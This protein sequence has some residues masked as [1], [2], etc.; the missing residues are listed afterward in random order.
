LRIPREGGTGEGL[1]AITSASKFFFLFIEETG[2]LMMHI[3]YFHTLFNERF[4]PSMHASPRYCTLIFPIRL[5]LFF[6]R[7][8]CPAIANDKNQNRCVSI[9]SLANQIYKAQTP[10]PRDTSPAETQ[11]LGGKRTKKERKPAG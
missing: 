2:E 8:I 10:I 11:T 7:N 4:R 3:P 5:R 6:M 9:V 1:H